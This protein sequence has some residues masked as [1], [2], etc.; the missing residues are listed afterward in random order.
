MPY[1]KTFLDFLYANFMRR[2]RKVLSFKKEVTKGVKSEG[3]VEGHLMGVIIF[4]A[5]QLVNSYLCNYYFLF[6][7]MTSPLK[8]V[9]SIE[10]KLLK[11]AD[12]Q[13]QLRINNEDYQKEIQELKKINEEYKKTIHQLEEKINTI[14]ITKTIESREGAVEAKERIAKLSAGNRSLHRAAEYIEVK[15]KTNG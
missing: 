12:Q 10:D 3:C 2:E 1:V 14:K 6:C 15:F 4:F 8:I 11:L 7:E 9:I 5:C 13:K